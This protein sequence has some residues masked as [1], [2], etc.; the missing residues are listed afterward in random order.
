MTRAALEAESS[1]YFLVPTEEP[2]DHLRAVSLA[3]AGKIRGMGNTGNNLPEATTPDDQTTKPDACDN[4]GMCRYNFTEMVVSLRLKDTPV[5]YRPPK[6]A[7]VFFTLT[8]NQ[9]EATQPAVFG[10]FNVGPRWSLN[11]LSYIVDDPALPGASVSRAVAGGGGKVYSGYDSGTGA[12]QAERKNG[13]V[14]VRIQGTPIVYERRL[15]DGSLEV[16]AHGDGAAT[17]PRRVFLTRRIDPAGNAVDLTYDSQ[18]RLMAITDATGR[19]TTLDYG[20]PD[21]PLAVT[22]VTDPFGRSAELTYDATGRLIAIT[23]VLGLTSSFVY[24]SAAQ[25]TSLTTPYGTTQFRFGGSGNSRYLEATD[26]LGYIERLEY[27]HNPPGVASS[28]PSSLVPTGVLGLRNQYLNYRNTIYWDKN[29]YQ[30]GAGIY[31]KGRIKHWTHL[32]STLT[33]DLVESIKHPL[34]S[35]IWNS[36]P[37]QANTINVGTLDK[38]NRVGRVL[39]DGTT[40]LTQYTYNTAGNVTSTTDPVG[41][42]TFFDYAAN[43][44]DV[45]AVRQ[46]TANGTATIASFTYNA[47]HRPLTAKDAAGKITTYTYNAAGQILTETNPLNQK[48]TYTYD[49]LG[50]LL[51]IQNPNGTT[52]EAYTCDAQGRIATRT[53]SEGHTLAYSYD[54]L[55]RVTSE[56]YPDGS[57]RTPTYD[58]LD[59]VAETDREGRTTHYEYDANRNRTAVIDPEGRRTAYGYDG[60]GRLVSLTDPNGNLTTWE[61]DLQ[62]RVTA[63]VFADG[64]RT[65]YAYESRTSRLKSRTDALGQI[66]TRTYTKDDRLTALGYTNAVN[67][68]PNLS[69]A[70]DAYF[71]RISS[72]TDGNGATTYS[73]GQVG[74]AGALQLTA[75]DGPFA[76]DRITYSYDGLGRVTQRIIDGTGDSTAYDV[77]GR[78][79]THSGPL[80][81]F[82][83]SYLGQT[84]QLAR[85]SVQQITGA[86]WDTTWQYGDNLHDRHLTAITHSGF[87][88]PARNYAYTT[89][90]VNRI[91]NLTESVAGNTNATW[92]YEYDQADRLLLARDTLGWYF[93]AYELDAADNP[94]QIQNVAG[95]ATATYDSLNQIALRNAQ[96]FVYDAAG[97]LLNDGRRSYT[98]DAEQRLIRIGYTGTNKS[99]EF[100][101]DGLGRRTSMREY[102]GSWNYTETRY[103]WCGERICQARNSSDTPIRRYYE[104]GEQQIGP[105]ITSYYYAQDHLGSVRDLV[106]AS[107]SG[108]ASYDYD[109]YGNP[110]RSTSNGSARADYRYAGLFYHA[111]SGLYLTHYR[112]YDPV[113]ARWLSRDPIGEA[114]GVNLYAYVEGN[115]VSY[116]DPLGLMNEAVGGFGGVGVGGGASGAAIGRAIGV[117]AGAGIVE[118][119]SG[120]MMA[121][122]GNV[123][124]TQIVQDYGAEAS[125]ARQ[126]GGEPPDRCKWLEENQHRYRADQV[127]RT[128]KAWG[129]RRS[130]H[131]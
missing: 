28:D 108:L 9:R 73:Y 106:D 17:Y 15:P 68:T 126:C 43:Q 94:L 74:I 65:S 7:P 57:A 78:V 51:R 24:N 26:P 3:E 58:K 67:A 77:L 50:Y 87:N 18:L 97:N 27:R 66:A 131:D 41:R 111:P 52:R 10:Y 63:K 70:Y 104:E 21:W 1:G 4:Q 125:D 14:L 29:A 99:T 34:E 107:G 80:G 124:D 8:Y 22:R 56:I 30:L 79:I 81:T 25:I 45:L 115:P 110:T 127:K 46:Q 76:H 82:A 35:R 69:F 62:G 60:D 16:Y 20:R 128:Q 47:Q 120:E 119:I 61:R 100:R 19:V 114:G 64:S 71:P 33:S 55:D 6:G 86:H 101:Y 121:A 39:D 93:T 53:D 37:G 118:G 123:A 36:Y 38:P 75:E 23:D 130:R 102:T 13:A 88:Q 72:M 84:N 92:A 103:L 116:A 42:V 105:N 2:P 85:R 48:T 44:I 113:T 12:F 96:P 5:G 54:A 109:P 32:T 112:A 95:I 90:P 31:T 117:V 91:L 129:C 11:W 40:Q 98:W 122:P 83:L 89:S 49:S 59:L